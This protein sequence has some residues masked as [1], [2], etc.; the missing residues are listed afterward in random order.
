MGNAFILNPALQF[1][2]LTYRVD[3]SSDL[4]CPPDRNHWDTVVGELSLGLQQLEEVAAC[5]E[6]SN[7]SMV[8]GS[9]PRNFMVLSVTPFVFFPS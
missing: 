3:L 5:W 9:G 1:T 4:R 7:Q 6:L 2:M 8:R